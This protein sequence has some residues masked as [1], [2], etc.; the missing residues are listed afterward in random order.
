MKQ[1]IISI[2]VILILLIAGCGN[3]DESSA[4]DENTVGTPVEVITVTTS[5]IVSSI[6]ATGVVEARYDADVSSEAVERVVEIVHDVGSRVSL[7][8]PVIQLDDDRARFNLQQAEAQFSI[9]RVARDKAEKD[10]KRMRELY[11]AEDVDVSDSEMEQAELMAEQAR[12]EFE[13]A[14]AALKLSRKALDD[15]GIRAPFDGVVTATYVNVGEMVVQGQIAY[16]IVQVDTIEIEVGISGTDI[17]RVRAQ[18]PVE[19][20]TTAIPD[21]LFRG[22]VA[23]VA[24]KA[25]EMTRTYAVKILS[26]NMDNGLRPG[27]LA[28]VSIITGLYEDVIA[29]PM[30]AV[31]QRNGRQTVFVEQSGIAVEREITV[32]SIHGEQMVISSGISAGERLIVSGQQSLQDGREVIVTD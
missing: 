25:S 28:D 30:D 2:G 19:I 15:T 6:E 11:A 5:D 7:G 18:L 14:D 21:R 23:S 10:I 32:T 26:E 31:I 29:I 16:T 3:S 20:R 13:L 4:G 9:A 22:E 24:L 8:E 17:A 27:M 12:G 1:A